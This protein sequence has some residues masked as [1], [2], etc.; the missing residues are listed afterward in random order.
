MSPSEMKEITTGLSGKPEALHANGLHVAG[1]KYVLG[2]VE[3]GRSLYARK[4]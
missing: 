2:K 4:V 3:D 1:V